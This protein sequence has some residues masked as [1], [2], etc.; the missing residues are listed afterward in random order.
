[1]RTSGTAS[2]DA[3][4][5]LVAVC[6]AVIVASACG[7]HPA[8][9]APLFAVME[10]KPCLGPCPV[11]TVYVYA[12]GTVEYNGEYSV[13]E[14]GMRVALVGRDKLAAIADAF[15]RAQFDTIGDHARAECT[16][17][18]GATIAY[19]GRTVRH[20]HGDPTA[21]WRLYTLEFD[22]DHILG[23]SRWVGREHLYV[24]ACGATDP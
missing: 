18:P 8:S 2:H 7:H 13:R 14:R 17:Q 21:P 24:P 23:T 5:K 20:N 9:T 12:D 1:V 22:I 15:A 11:Y 6:I 16:C 3:A 10:R 19:N 4:M